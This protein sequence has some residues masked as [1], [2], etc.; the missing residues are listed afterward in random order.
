MKKLIAAGVLAFAALTACSA[1]G[2]DPVV[3]EVPVNPNLAPQIYPNGVAVAD[4]SMFIAL[5]EGNGYPGAFYNK[6]QHI[7]DGWAAC[8]A[9]HTGKTYQPAGVSA[10]DAQTLM[11][12]AQTY[13]CPRSVTAGGTAPYSPS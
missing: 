8:A 1:C 3:T 12:A 9:V 2:Q 7:E 11:K 4:P 5:L 10:K 13:L 6:D